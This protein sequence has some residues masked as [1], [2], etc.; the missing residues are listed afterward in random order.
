MILNDLAEC[1][2][3]LGKKVRVKCRKHALIFKMLIYWLL[4]SPHFLSI[5]QAII[6]SGR[7]DV[8]SREVNSN[9]VEI[10]TLDKGTPLIL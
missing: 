4:V 1:I 6:T 10:Q 9:V 7:L 8:R 3:H 5:I 2:Q